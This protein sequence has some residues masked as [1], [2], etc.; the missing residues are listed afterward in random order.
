MFNQT[1]LYL[2]SSTS[3]AD[4]CAALYKELESDQNSHM[5]RVHFTPSV[6]RAFVDF[7]RMRVGG[8]VSRLPKGFDRIYWMVIGGESLSVRD[9]ELARVVF[10]A[11]TI[12]CN[13]AVSVLF[14]SSCETIFS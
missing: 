9:L 6:F 12:A 2:D 8:S 14:F 4:Q 11:A 1:T 7:S 5:L 13:Y 3:V 10:P